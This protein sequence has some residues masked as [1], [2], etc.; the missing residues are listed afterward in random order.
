MDRI[1]NGFFIRC[2]D[3]VP[4]W[5]AYP[6][7][8]ERS[9]RNILVEQCFHRVFSLTLSPVLKL[10][11][12]LVPVLFLLTLAQAQT[13][14]RQPAPVMGVAGADWLT[15]PERIQEENPDRMLARWK[16]SRAPSSRILER[17]WAITRGGWPISWAQP[18]E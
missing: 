5:T 12:I 1:E 9:E 10:R 6:E 4:C 3:E 16:S 2:I 15:R 7:C 17:A 18:E 11:A 14:Q 13:V 8:C